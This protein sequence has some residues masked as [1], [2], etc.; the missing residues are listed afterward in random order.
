MCGLNV[1][2]LLV[3]NYYYNFENTSIANVELTTNLIK[4]GIKLNPIISGV[5]LVS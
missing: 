2:Y 3:L 1:S 5:V 4:L